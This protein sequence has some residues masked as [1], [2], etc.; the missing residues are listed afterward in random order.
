ME[1]L[2]R[3]FDDGENLGRVKSLYGY[4]ITYLHAFIAGKAL[5]VSLVYGA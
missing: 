5:R 4:A 3:T 1:T 2:A